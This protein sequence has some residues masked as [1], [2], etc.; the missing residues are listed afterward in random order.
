MFAFLAAGMRPGRRGR[1][2][3]DV[4]CGGILA[5]PADK[6]FVQGQQTKGVERDAKAM[7]LSEGLVIE[8]VRDTERKSAHGAMVGLSCCG[9]TQHHIPDPA[10]PQ[11]WL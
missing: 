2:G 3:R 11:M 6:V 5:A 9:F 8:C 1:L 4:I 7:S 10:M